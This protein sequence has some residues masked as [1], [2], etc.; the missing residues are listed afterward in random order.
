MAARLQ[1]RILP[2]WTGL[3]TRAVAVRFGVTDMKSKLLGLA[4]AVALFGTASMAQATTLTQIDISP[5]VNEGFDNGGWFINGS[6][7]A[8]IVGSTFGNQGSSIPFN[9]ASAPKLDGG[10]NNFWFGLFD[11]SIGSSSLFGPLGSV[12]IPIT[13]ANVTT[14]YTLADNTFGNEANTEF[15]VTFNGTAGPLTMSY[16]GG[17][18][19]KDYNLNCGTTGC[20]TTPNASYW[21]VDPEGSQWLQRVQ[22]NLPANF[23]LTSIT[24]DQ[25]DGTDGAILA[26]VTIASVPE[27][28]T[29]ALML[30]GF[31]TLGYALRRR[32]RTAA[33]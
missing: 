12:T 32:T 17:D 25:V 29:W 14:V 1:H 18:N 3:A 27:P 19:T 28:S 22:W 23:G 9:V 31:G 7:F 4:A 8:P 5:Y 6:D 24:F 13:T 26:G 2:R 33:A 16:V 20:D 11:P 30:V 15:T 21:F 10:T